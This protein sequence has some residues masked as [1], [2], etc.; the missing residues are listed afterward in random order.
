[1]HVGGCRKISLYR[2]TN[3]VGESGERAELGIVSPEFA[4]FESNQSL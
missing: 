4:R 1:M 2:A 3:G